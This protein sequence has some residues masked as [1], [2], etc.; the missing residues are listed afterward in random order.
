MENANSKR[1]LYLKAAQVAEILQINVE[2]VY[3]LIASEQLPATK[4]GG[5]W[6][7]DESAVHRWFQRRCQSMVSDQERAA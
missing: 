3:D 6:R 4:V 2:K 7:F 5:Q 1:P